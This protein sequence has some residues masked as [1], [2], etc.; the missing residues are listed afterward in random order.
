MPTIPENLSR[1]Q[2]LAS[3]LALSVAGC[4]GGAGTSGGGSTGT[5]VTPAPTPAPTPTPTPS[6]AAAN[7]K[8]SAAAKKMRF[9]SS[10]AWSGPGWDVASFANPNYAALIEHDCTILVPEN[11]MKWAIVQP[12][13][14]TP[15]WTQFDAMM[16]Y[17]ESKGI[18]MRGTNLVWHKRD[19]MP[20]W[21]ESHDYGAD[22]VAEA[23]R[24]LTERIQN[25]CRR[26]GTRIYSYDV[27]NEGVDPGSGGLNE[28]ALSQAMGGAQTLIDL[29]F[30]TAR[31]E[32]PGAQLVY[33]DYM[34][35]DAGSTHRDGVLAL[36]R[37]FKARGVPCD[38]LGV[39]SHLASPLPVAN[40]IANQ[41]PG[42]RAFLDEVVGMGYKLVITELDV[43]DGGFPGDIATRDQDV[44][45]YARGYLDLMFSYPQLTDV[46]VWGLCDKYSWLQGFQPRG[47]GLKQR[48]DPYDA[49]FQPKL[50]Q[51]AINAAFVA[52]TARP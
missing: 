12:T 24:I 41:T 18:A 49:T 21:T 42:W 6:I 27:I 32:A 36:L 33:N 31:A 48:C 51:N 23:K 50:M 17:A 35:W 22:P 28:T 46:L 40:A 25:V 39:E 26:Y 16:A 11:E 15:D 5:I 10:F 52:T 37:G 13:N 14:T 1:R 47:D 29:A 4:S 43:S 20:A 19:T 3:L 7:I 38:A 9:G 30:R 34:G 8:G 2:T 45:D 44:A